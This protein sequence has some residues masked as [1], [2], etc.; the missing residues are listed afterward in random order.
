MYI[1]DNILKAQL[2]N[3][4]FINGTAYAGKSTMCRML[5]EA[6]G[7]Y[8]CEENYHM[9]RMLAMVE[10]ESQPNLCYF[11]GVDW[12][13]FVTRSPEAYK[14]WVDG[15]ALEITDFELTELLRLTGRYPEKKIIVDTNIPAQVLWKI[16][17]YWRVAI[18]L[19]D[20]QMAV[21]RFFDRADPEKQFLFGQIERTPDPAWTLENFRQGIALINGPEVLE[22]WRTSGFYYRERPADGSDTMAETFAALSKHF[23]FIE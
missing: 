22:A 8:H 12:Q 2:Q 11:H 13:D 21:E 14:A 18:L 1:Q 9:D 7:L 4:Y 20:T 5:A 16:S 19:S 6:Y 3:C 10:P 17:D 15:N 23:G